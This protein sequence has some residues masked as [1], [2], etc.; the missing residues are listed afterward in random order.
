MPTC[1]SCGETFPVSM[2]IDG[3]RKNLNRRK[4]CL[5]CS[6]Y[7]ALKESSLID[8]GTET[9]TC[10]KC[11]TEKPLSEFYYK[12]DGGKPRPYTYCKTCWGKQS[13]DRTVEMKRK[14][15]DYK[16]GKCQS[17]GYDRYIGALEFHHKN[18]SE[19]TYEI[20]QKLKC[21]S[22]EKLKIELDKCVL[23]CCRCHDEIEGG[24]IECPA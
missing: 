19:K 5:K 17:C 12:N 24:I 10:P 23:V 14:C 7:K 13:T 6:P 1:T 9:K 16:G 21:Y 8:C 15:V 11:K 3:E 4:R 18:A 22:F 20:S 2:V